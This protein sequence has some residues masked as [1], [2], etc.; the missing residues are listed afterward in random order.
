MSRGNNLNRNPKKSLSTE[1]R[2]YGYIQTCTST[3]DGRGGEIK[4]WVN[5]PSEPQALAVLP[6]SAHQINH[7]KS[8][9]VE[10]SILIKIRA[11]VEIK[12]TSRVLVGTRIFEIQKIEN[13]QERDIVNWALCKESRT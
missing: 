11:E 12:E 1:S 3:D 10:A 9:N 7:Y 13:I 4:V 8:I 5:S 2:N 6:M